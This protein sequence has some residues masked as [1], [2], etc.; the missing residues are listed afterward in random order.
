MK[1]NFLSFNK[2][3]EQIPGT[4]RW[5]YKILFLRVLFFIITFAIT[6][7]VLSNNITTGILSRITNFTLINYIKNNPVNPFENVASVGGYLFGENILLFIIIYFEYYT[8]KAKKVAGFWIT[9]IF[10][11]LLVIS[12]PF[13]PII[14]ITILILK[15]IPSIKALF[16][17]K[18]SYDD[19]L[20][21][22]NF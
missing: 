17:K 15:L 18:D 3:N 6:I 21:D 9:W 7:Y 4:Q 11:F 16:S 20:L 13:L 22:T 14:P 2:K 8:L 19:D 5:I 12:Y 10:D 1:I